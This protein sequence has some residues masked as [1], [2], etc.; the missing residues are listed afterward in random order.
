MFLEVTVKKCI[1]RD[2]DSFKK[3]VIILSLAVPAMIE[4]LL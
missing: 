3:I 4:N 1:K 2:V